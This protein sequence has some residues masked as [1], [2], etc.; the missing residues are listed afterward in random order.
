MTSIIPVGMAHAATSPPFIRIFL[1]GPLS[2][3]AFFDLMCCN[4]F[5]K[6]S[7]PVCAKSFGFR[8]IIL[9]VPFFIVLGN[10]FIKN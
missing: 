5:I 7:C 3:P 10:V 1:P 8:K 9:S 6:S 4:I 2:V